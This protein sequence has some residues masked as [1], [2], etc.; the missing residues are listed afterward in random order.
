[1]TLGSIEK[2]ERLDSRTIPEAHL[3]GLV[4]GLRLETKDGEESQETPGLSSRVTGR[5]W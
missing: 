2:E 1:M 4:S 5:C 3:V